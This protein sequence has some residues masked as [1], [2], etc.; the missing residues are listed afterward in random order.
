MAIT[1]AQPAPYSPCRWRLM[2]N[3]AD[4]FHIHHPAS[5]NAALISAF[6]CKWRPP[7]QF[8]RFNC[9][10]EINMTLLC[11]MLCRGN[12]LHSVAG[13]EAL[14]TFSVDDAR[15]STDSYGS[16]GCPSSRRGTKKGAENC[17]TTVSTQGRVDSWKGR[18]FIE[19]GLVWRRIHWRYNVNSVR[20]GG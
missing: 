11:A 20:G 15:K 4:Y 18:H 9:N 10:S 2:V 14:S 17:I 5:M 1:T 6:L 16:S 12:S 13:G 8:A 7:L 3:Y 19:R